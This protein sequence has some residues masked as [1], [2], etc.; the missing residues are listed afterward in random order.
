MLIKSYQYIYLSNIILFYIIEN[1]M[2][3]SNTNGMIESLYYFI[4]YKDDSIDDKKYWIRLPD[5]IIYKN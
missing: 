5:T 1:W 2:F 4:W 3:L